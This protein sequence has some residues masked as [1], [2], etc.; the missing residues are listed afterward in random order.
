LLERTWRQPELGMAVAPFI[1]RGQNL[2]FEIVGRGEMTTKSNA[3][4]PLLEFF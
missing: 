2:G 3:V 4:Q 1:E